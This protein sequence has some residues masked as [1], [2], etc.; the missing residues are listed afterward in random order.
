MDSKAAIVALGIGAAVIAGPASAQ[1]TTAQYLSHAYLGGGIGQSKA[2]DGCSGVSGTGVSCDDK[3]TAFKLFA[4]YQLNRNFAAELGYTN[5][6]KVNASVPGA[7]TDIKTQLGE[8]SAIGAFPVWQEL[9][10]FGRLGGYYA[11]AKMEGALTG[12]KKTGGFTYGAG[13]QYDFMR[14]LGV[15]G[16]WQRYA[17]IKAREDAT[18][19]EGESDYD[20]LA[21]NVIWR[22][23]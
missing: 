12:S 14:N 19:A 7:S 3:D 8:L 16:E 2:K 13:V 4:G 1:S 11:D 5:L 15:R 22:F 10:I 20:L 23:Q 17:K 9:S 18:G 21:I 6:G